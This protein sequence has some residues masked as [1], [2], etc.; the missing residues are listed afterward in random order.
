MTDAND[1]DDRVL[2]VNKPVQTKSQLHSQ[3]KA[4][5]G[6]IGLYVNVNSTHVLN[7][8]NHLHS[9]CQT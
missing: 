1:A 4:A 6:S 5:V 7:E 8:K 9:Q 3:E 2:L